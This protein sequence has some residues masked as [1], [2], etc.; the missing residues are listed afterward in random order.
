[1]LGLFALARRSTWLRAFATVPAPRPYRQFFQK[2]HRLRSVAQR[3]YEG[4]HDAQERL[5]LVSEWTARIYRALFRQPG[6]RAMQSTIVA[7]TRAASRR[8]VIGLACVALLFVAAHLLLLDL[9]PINWEYAFSDAAK[10]FSSG[11]ARYLDQY[12][13]HEANTLTVPWLAFAIQ[14]L[15]PGLDIDHV[16]RL[17]SALGIPFLAY[18]LLRINRQLAESV[19]PYLLISIVL[20]NPLVWTFAG[21]GTADFLPAALSIFSLSLFWRGQEESRSELWRRILASTVLGLAAIIKYHALLLLPGIVAEIAINRRAKYGRMLVEG[22]ASTAPA[23]LVLATYLLI[24]K[25]NFG[26]WITPPKFQRALGLALSQGLDNLLSYSGY[27]IL[28]TLPLSLVIPRKWIS[29][30][31]VR[32]G[33]AMLFLASAFVLGYF[34][35]SDN[36]EMNLGPLD[37]YVNKHIA[38]GLLAMFCA[39]LPIRLAIG[40]DHSASKTKAAALLTALTVAIVFF[41]FALSL[42]RPA[43]RY[44]LFILPLFYFFLL[45]SQKYHRATIAFAILLSIALD[46]YILLNQVAS[47]IASEEM[48]RRIAELGLLS[49][50][51]AGP[52]E[53]NVGDRFFPYRHENKTFAVVVGNV[54]GSI[55]QVHYSVFPQ[56]PF[57]GKTYSL[58]RLQPLPSDIG[59]PLDHTRK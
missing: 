28:I 25:I 7:R 44:L 14:R 36:G 59:S 38:N 47:G 54:A 26:F 20:V 30:F 22:A 6:K 50:T 51:A 32:H 35:L 52:I 48:A 5:I 17:L 24:V 16:P 31:G 10:Y 13:D 23:I 39:L 41:I 58:V 19:N 29:D 45:P 43:Q 34:F 46:I 33:A 27:L 9:P 37:P 12:F 2:Q 49:K 53:G 4:A 18:G 55:V 56:I 15:F 8:P 21:R 11:D 57:T 1:M 3:L 40:L 42:T